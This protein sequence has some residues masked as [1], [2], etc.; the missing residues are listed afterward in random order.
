MEHSSDRKGA[1]A[2]AACVFHALRLGYDVYR[3]VFEG[4]RNDLVI[5]V[6]GALLRAQVKWAEQRGDV[7]DVRCYSSRRAREGI[8]RRR[9]TAAEVDVLLAFCP[10]LDR[11]FAIGPDA[12]DGRAQLLLRLAPCR[13]G[14]RRGINWAD[15]FAFESLQSQSPMGP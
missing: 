2:E 1:I 4:G 13:N 10:Q 15:D 7:I 8:R 14:Q 12:F 3:P 6:D 5:G 9:Y 11:V